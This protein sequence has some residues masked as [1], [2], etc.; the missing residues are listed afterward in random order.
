[1]CESRLTNVS[2]SQ[3]SIIL[4]ALAALCGGAL[5]A[6]VWLLAVR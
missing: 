4:T 1:M 2:A 6:A 5:I 3:L